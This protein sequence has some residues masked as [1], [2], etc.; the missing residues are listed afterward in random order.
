MG[1]DLIYR[2]NGE[3]FIHR[4]SMSDWDTLDAVRQI[5]PEAVAKMADVPELGAEV[6]VPLSDLNSAI[7]QIDGLLRDQPDLLPYTYQTAHEM[8]F[9]DGQTVRFGFSTGGIG[10]I[11]LPGDEDHWYFIR[12]G[13]N[14]C[15][16]EKMGMQPDGT[17]RVVEERDLRGEREL[18]TANFGRIQIRRRRA[19]STLRKGVAEIR[20]FL[21]K[22][23]EGAEV[24]KVVC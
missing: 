1:L 23:P 2:C 24:S 11:R 3:E 22:Q 4:F 5:C 17:V 16:L 6:C 21:A 15:R 7:E 18:Q 14:E 10:G 12:A 9:N 20:G 19:K 13:L 8:S